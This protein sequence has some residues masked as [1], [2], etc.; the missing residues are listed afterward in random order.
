LAWTAQTGTSLCGL[1]FFLAVVSE[2]LFRRRRSIDAAYYAAGAAAAAIVSSSIVFAHAYLAGDAAEWQFTGV[3][4]AYGVASLVLNLRR[5]RPLLSY[6]GSGLIAAALAEAGFL[7][8]V[9]D[10]DSPWMAVCL[11]HATI[12]MA[13]GFAFGRFANA[14]PVFVEPLLLSATLSSV[15]SLAALLK[16]D[17]QPPLALSLHLGWLAALW[18]VLA[19]RRR[20]ADWFAAFQAALAGSVVAAITAWLYEQPWVDHQSRAL[21]DPRSLQVYGI[22]LSLLCAGWS[23]AR[24]ALRRQA[25]AALFFNDDPV[26]VDRW[27]YRL[28]AIGGLALAAWGVAPGVLAELS[29]G[30]VAVIPAGSRAAVV[31]GP[32]AWWL[33]AAQSFALVVALWDRWRGGEVACGV[34]LIVASAVLAAGPFASSSATASALRWS[35]SGAFAIASTFVWLRAPLARGLQKLGCRCETAGH[36]S[37]IAQGLLLSLCAAPVLTVTGAVVAMRIDGLSP[38]GPAPG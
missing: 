5:R 6:L 2:L 3:C 26:P 9:V 4:A 34:L 35:L 29:S 10:I 36:G 38:A 23:A 18:L 1:F 33:V 14:A 13:L 17:Q 32:F 12:S 20:S 21:A 25:V 37:S 11:G 19:V 31:F 8:P 24:I 30:G 15:A 28:L 16:I 27:T 22:G 7:H